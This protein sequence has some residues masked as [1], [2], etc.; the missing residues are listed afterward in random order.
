MKWKW[1][2]N[3]PTVN[4]KKPVSK[5]T[6]S[7]SKAKMVL[8]TEFR[9][10]MPLTCEEY[11]I[12]QLYAT[13]QASKVESQ[14]KDGSSVTFLKNEPCEHPKYSL[15]CTLSPMTSLSFIAL[16]PSSIIPYL[17]V[18]ERTIHSQRVQHPETTSLVA[19]C[20]SAI[21]WN[22]SSRRKL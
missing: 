6:R 16:S 9:I 22:D 8:I 20:Y 1:R 17:Q 10:P 14:K 7:A 11:R 19:A 3:S 12:G 18:R 2:F 13:A 5:L 21:F 4:C 15:Y